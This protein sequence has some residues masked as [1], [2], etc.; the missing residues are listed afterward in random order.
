MK[1][2]F[3]PYFSALKKAGYRGRLSIEA[4][5]GDLPAELPL[6]LKVLRRQIAE[7]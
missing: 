6:A 5:W 7:V 3:R 4:G 2:D 1:D